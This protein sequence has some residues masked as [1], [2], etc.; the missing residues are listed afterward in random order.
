MQCSAAKKDISFCDVTIHWIGLSSVG[1]HGKVEYW[2]FQL[3][4]YLLSDCSQLFTYIPPLRVFVCWRTLVDGNSPS[5]KL[6]QNNFLI[7]LVVQTFLF[8]I[9]HR[10]L[11]SD[12]I[13][14]RI[15]EEHKDEKSAPQGHIV[16]VLYI[17]SGYTV[18]NPHVWLGSFNWWEFSL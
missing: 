5:K 15:H 11:Y 7:V 10:S 8:Q 9:M 2:T 13:C 14:R 12:Y 1:T 18:Y 16:Y 17:C 4:Y 6:W 3:F